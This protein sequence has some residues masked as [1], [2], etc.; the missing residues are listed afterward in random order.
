VYSDDAD[1]VNTFG[2]VRR[3]RDDIVEYLRGC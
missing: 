2:T 1:R 3:G